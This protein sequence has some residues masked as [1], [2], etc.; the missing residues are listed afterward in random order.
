MSL[1]HLDFYMRKGIGNQ[2][3]VLKPITCV[4]EMK[5]VL[6]LGLSVVLTRSAAGSMTTSIAIGTR[7]CFK[8]SSLQL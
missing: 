1:T 2:Y 8:M 4:Y 5:S 6:C 3:E 7:A